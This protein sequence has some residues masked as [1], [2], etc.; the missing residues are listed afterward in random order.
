MS[1]LSPNNTVS[2]V[3]LVDDGRRLALVSY[4]GA[5]RLAEIEI[6]PLRAVQLAGQLIDVAMRRLSA[7]RSDTAGKGCSRGGDRRRGNRTARNLAIREYAELLGGE[8]SLE[9]K[10]REIIA[11]AA[12]YRPV[13]GDESRGGERQVLARIAA[14]ELPV[15]G[16]RQLRRI[17]LSSP[18]G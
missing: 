9:T 5:D 7:D 2:R 3:V 4:A 11:R 14:T 17:L 8:L 6:E 15:P 1:L 16:P 12:R 18:G 13:S 10:A